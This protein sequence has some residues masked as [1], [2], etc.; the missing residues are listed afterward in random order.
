MDIERVLPQLPQSP[1]HSSQQDGQTGQQQVPQQPLQ[2][3]AV[4]LAQP[5]PLQPVLP[6]PMTTNW[7]KIS[8]TRKHFSYMEMPS[9]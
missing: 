2:Q 7:S 6:T 3:P 9:H 4:L 1:G 5:L 8:N